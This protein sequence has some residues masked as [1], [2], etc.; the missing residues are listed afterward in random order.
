M[1]IYH[2]F[3]SRPFEPE[4]IAVMTSAYSDVCDALGLRDRDH[5]ETNAVAKKIIELA[6]RGE[7][8]PGRLR[9]TVLRAMQY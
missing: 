3:R 8:D 6:Q 9:E 7:R 2:L 4:A 1:G 5:V